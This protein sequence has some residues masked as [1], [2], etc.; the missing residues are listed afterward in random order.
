MHAENSW[1][2]R[3]RELIFRYCYLLIEEVTGVK[4]RTGI[5]NVARRIASLNCVGFG[6]SDLEKVDPRPVLCIRQPRCSGNDG[7]C[8]A[9]L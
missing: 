7:R 6:R 3:R 4:L 1:L 2:S 9:A 8:G 5:E